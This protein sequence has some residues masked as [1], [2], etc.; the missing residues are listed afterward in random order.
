MEYN[1]EIFTRLGIS[2]LKPYQELIIS[3]VLD[4][5]TGERKINILGCLPTGSG[6]T[7]CFMYPILALKKTDGAYLSHSFAHE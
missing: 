5:I 1:K 2:Y 4:G 3:S 6:K 7:L